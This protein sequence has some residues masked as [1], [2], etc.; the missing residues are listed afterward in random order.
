MVAFYRKY[1]KAD[2]GGAGTGLAARVALQSEP[3][4]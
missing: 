2:S 1:R 4:A 3:A